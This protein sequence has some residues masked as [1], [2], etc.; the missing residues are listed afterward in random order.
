MAAFVNQCLQCIDGKAGIRLPRPLR[1]VVHDTEVDE[2]IIFERETT[3]LGMK[4]SSIFSSWGR[5]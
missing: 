5:T 3:A 2:V 4:P 1:E